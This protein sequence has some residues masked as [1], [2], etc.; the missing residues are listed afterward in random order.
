MNINSY[1]TLSS[2][3]RKVGPNR[4]PL[5]ECVEGVTAVPKD[6]TGL[7]RRYLDALQQNVRARRAYSALFEN[8]AQQPSASHRVPQGSSLSEHMELLR[9]KQRHQE[10]QVL[11][12]CMT[13]LRRTAAARPESLGLGK[14]LGHD[15]NPASPQYHHLN[16]G[17]D[18]AQDSVHALVRQLEIAVLRA[19]DQVDLERQLLVEVERD[20][21]VEPAF[22]KQRNRPRALAITRDELVSWID[23]KLP[24]ATSDEICIED[25][26][27]R[28][29]ET[30]PPT[31]QLH[32][33][34][35]GK[36]DKYIKLRKEMLGL[37]SGLAKANQCHVRDVKPVQSQS[38]PSIQSFQ[39][40]NPSLLSSILSQ[41]HRPTQLYRFYT[42][43]NTHLAALTDK[44]RK[45]T[46]SELSRLADE[47]HLLPAYSD[48]SHGNQF[49]R[50]T[51]AIASKPLLRDPMVSDGPNEV[52]RRVEAWRSAADAATK[53]SEEIVESHLAKG[54]DAI[55]EGNKWVAR[56]QELLV[57]SQ[58]GQNERG[59]ERDDGALN[60][61]DEDEDVWTLEAA[62]GPLA[63]GS[64]FQGTE[65][66]WAGL[67]GDLGLK[68]ET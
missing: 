29:Q 12:S 32:G 67:R 2:N 21:L 56:M 31:S 66:Q 28:R 3:A 44:Q 59:S 51:A 5:P 35:M 4:L 11:Q 41:I 39:S 20:V 49:E 22:I 52:S 62:V 25:Q 34:I 7:E 13:E 53:A 24:H 43:Q 27:L 30:E 46:I 57:D 48:L 45:T 16:G 63:G 23:D 68:R 47:S 58:F 42:Q 50:V 14:F 40:K 9:L 65:D 36:Y 55:D 19:Q 15:Q 54:H 1:I 33:E 26:V 6:I 60:N 64:G 10:L 37:L 17:I 61:R 18:Q 8:P 38:K